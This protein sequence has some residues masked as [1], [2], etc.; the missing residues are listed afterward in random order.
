MNKRVDDVYIN[1]KIFCHEVF[2]EIPDIERMSIIPHFFAVVGGPANFQLG[3][4]LRG[5]LAR[6]YVRTPWNA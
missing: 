1:L 3:S 2:P 4:N 6:G 5:L